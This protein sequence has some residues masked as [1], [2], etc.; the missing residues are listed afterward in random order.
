M[1]QK[2]SAE[3]Y[4]GAKWQRQNGYQRWRLDQLLAEAEASEASRVTKE[5][6]IEMYGGQAVLDREG[7]DV[8]PCVDCKDPVC[9]GWMVRRKP[10]ASVPTAANGTGT[11]TLSETIAGLREACAGVTVSTVVE[12]TE[13]DLAVADELDMLAAHIQEYI[14][15]D[16]ARDDIRRI[17]RNRAEDLRRGVKRGPS[18]AEVIAAAEKALE[19]TESGAWDGHYGKG[20]SVAYARS[21]SVARKNAL[22]AI[23]KYKEAQNAYR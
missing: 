6:W 12:P 7:F 9:H 17:C 15:P 21:V 22:A 10:E 13:A 19:D 1:S 16:D 5:R 8:V 20:L 14:G 11:L 2:H 3:F 4:R 18:A 23:A